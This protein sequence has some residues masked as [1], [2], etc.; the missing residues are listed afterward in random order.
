[1]KFVWKGLGL[2]GEPAVGSWSRSFKS[3]QKNAITALLA[4]Q[5][6]KTGEPNDIL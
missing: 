2:G 5:N 6:I 1:M 4:D 3:C